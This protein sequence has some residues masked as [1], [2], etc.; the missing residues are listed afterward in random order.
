MNTSSHTC[1]AAHA[2][3]ATPSQFT[4]SGSHERVVVNATFA[5]QVQPGTSQSE[6][7]GTTSH[8]IAGAHS[9]V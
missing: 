4:G 2:Q 9:P 1:D 7:A 8:A 5:T 6:H 3:L